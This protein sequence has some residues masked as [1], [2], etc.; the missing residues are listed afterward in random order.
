M[1]NHEDLELLALLAV[2]ALWMASWPIRLRYGW[3]V[4]R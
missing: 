2:F 3:G 4:K 1:M